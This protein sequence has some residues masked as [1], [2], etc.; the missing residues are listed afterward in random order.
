ME[1][2][3]LT[4]SPSAKARHQSANERPAHDLPRGAGKRGRSTGVVREER[5]DRHEVLPALTQH[6]RDVEPNVLERFGVLARF[7]RRHE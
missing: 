4:C 7:G 3:W 6:R 5:I 2:M 1:E